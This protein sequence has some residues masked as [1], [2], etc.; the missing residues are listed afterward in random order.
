VSGNA[1]FI[2]I[3]LIEMAN[4]ISTETKSKLVNRDNP[5]L[6][7]LVLSYAIEN[8]YS[9]NEIADS[10]DVSRMTIHSWI[11]GSIARNKNLAK[12]I[13]FLEFHPL[14]LS[15]IEN[16]AP[17]N[18]ID[19][20]IIKLRAKL[21]SEW[22]CIIKEISKLQLEKNNIESY[23]LQ[24]KYFK[25][26]GKKLLDAAYAGK[27]DCTLPILPWDVSDIKKINSEDDYLRFC[28]YLKNEL[29]NDGFAVQIYDE[30]YSLSYLVENYE[31]LKSKLLMGN[32]S[33]LKALNKTIDSYLII[34]I[35]WLPEE[36]WDEE[37]D[38][39][40]DKLSW[41]LEWL[42]TPGLVVIDKIITKIKSQIA[43]GKNNLDLATITISKKDY[44]EDGYNESTYYDGY[45]IPVADVYLKIFFNHLGYHFN[46][47]RNY[48]WFNEHL[49]TISWK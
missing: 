16:K 36:D 24:K 40:E 31:Y 28:D 18:S 3:N 45:E 47:K 32:D 9:I 15:L 20:Q 49:I 27:P 5:T 17:I 34:N 25:Y 26:F 30:R 29:V 21:I 33:D 38:D 4:K 48:P 8:S 13:L 35:D 19:L 6:A 39:Y 46:F 44:D 10:A 2:Y 7:M 22:D 43:L 14:V 1:Q 23:L 12:M 41:F 42:H 37:K 11:N